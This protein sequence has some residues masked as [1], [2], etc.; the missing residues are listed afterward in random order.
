MI[1][2]YYNYFIIIS[3]SIVPLQEIELDA[4]TPKTLSMKDGPIM[5]AMEKTLQEIGVQ[6]QAYHG[7]AFVGNYVHT[8]CK[9]YY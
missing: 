8:C 2:F 6:R 4:M 5:I 3:D 7:H 1:I 9:V